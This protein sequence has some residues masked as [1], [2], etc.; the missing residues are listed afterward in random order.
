MQ[1]TPLATQLLSSS[2]LISIPRADSRTAYFSRNNRKEEMPVLL[3]PGLELG[4]QQNQ[5]ADTCQGSNLRVKAKGNAEIVL[6]CAGMTFHILCGMPRFAAIEQPPLATRCA[7]CSS[8]KGLAQAGARNWRPVP[9]GHTITTFVGQP[10]QSDH[11]LIESL[12]RGHALL[13]T[14]RWP[15]AFLVQSS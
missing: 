13:G 12:K 5:Q 6:K 2:R 11:N 14:G 15:T 9:G 10:F 4:N 3:L 8:G 7:S 1:G